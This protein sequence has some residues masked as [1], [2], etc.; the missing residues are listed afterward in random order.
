MKSSKHTG[1][2]N[3]EVIISYRSHYWAWDAVHTDIVVL[4]VAVLQ[5]RWL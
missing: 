2:D 1:T 5:L 3:V 4:C